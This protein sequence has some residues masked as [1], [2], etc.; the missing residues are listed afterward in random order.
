MNDLQARVIKAKRRVAARLKKHYRYA[1][2]FGYSAEESS[3]LMNMSQ[4]NIA[5]QAR[6]DGMSGT[7]I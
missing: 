1:R 4:E 5:M 3:L 6:K 7:S 2:D